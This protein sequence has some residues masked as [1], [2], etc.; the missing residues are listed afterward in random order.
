MAFY[1]KRPNDKKERIT[2]RSAMNT[3]DKSAKIL[4]KNYYAKV[5]K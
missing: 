3:L 1:A 4:E 2:E 5:L